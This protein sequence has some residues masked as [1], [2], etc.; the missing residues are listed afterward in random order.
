MHNALLPS[1]LDVLTE[2]S[3][4]SFAFATFSQMIESA[5]KLG[6]PTHQPGGLSCRAFHAS[7]LF[8]IGSPADVVVKSQLAQEQAAAAVTFAAA[9]GFPT[10]SLSTSV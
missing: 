6:R 10:S 8:L 3:I 7:L 1:S 4:K 2:P 5:R 9:Q